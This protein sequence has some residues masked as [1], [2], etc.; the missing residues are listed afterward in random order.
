MAKKIQ[1]DVIANDKASREVKKIGKNTER[2]FKN[3]QSSSAKLGRSMRTSI[4]GAVTS[5]NAGMRTLGSRSNRVFKSMINGAKRYKTSIDNASKSMQNLGRRKGGGLGDA[6]GGGGGFGLASVA[7]IGA[8][9]SLAQSAG[10]ISKGFAEGSKEARTLNTIIRTT[11]GELRTVRETINLNARGL[12]RMTEAGVGGKF[13]S[14][15][16]GKEMK[17]TAAGIQATRQKVNDLNRDFGGLGKTIKQVTGET[18]ALNK[19]FRMTGSVKDNI[20]AVKAAWLK[21]LAVAVAVKV[22][23]DWTKMG[24][25]AMQQQVAFRNMATS[26][27]HDADKILADLK[28]LSGGTVS[29]MV[30]IQKAGTAMMLGIDPSRL[31][32][33]MG[34]ARAT[35]RLTGQEVSEAFGDIAMAVGRQ[36]RMILDNL[37][38]IVNVGE[39]NKRYAKQLKKTVKQLSDYDRK[40]AFLNETIRKGAVLVKQ[41]DVNAKSTSETFQTWGATF[42]N[43]KVTIGKGLVKVFQFIEKMSVVW[44]TVLDQGFMALKFTFAGFG[45][46]L[47]LTFIDAFHEIKTAWAKTVNYIKNKVPDFLKDKLGIDTSKITLPI[48]KM[49]AELRKELTMTREHYEEERER[50]WDVGMGLLD[51]L[52]KAHS[53]GVTK[54]KV[55][56]EAEITSVEIPQEQLDKVKE[57][58]EGFVKDVRTSTPPVEEYEDMEDIMQ[59]IR[60]IQRDIMVENGTWVQQFLYG[61]GL[62]MEKVDSWGETMV[63]IGEQINNVMANN[64]TNAFEDFIDGTKTAKEAF[65][66]Y[67]KNV[68]KWLGQIIVKQLI[69]NGL[70]SLGGMGGGTGWAGI[71][72]SIA[73]TAAKAG[74]GPVSGGKPYL[75]GERGPELFVPSGAGSIKSNQETVEAAPIEVNIANLTDPAMMDAYIASSRGQ[76]AILNVIGQKAGQVRRMVR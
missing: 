33:L 56:V 51:D 38:I 60:A 3:V 10:R 73:S 44:I 19:S 70:K 76:N 18:K 28:R 58:A 36:S 16:F 64:L 7:Q 47:K 15:V 39:A 9:G 41:L 13:Q 21:F 23:V 22:A 31:A 1:I 27:G 43:L 75:V 5:I 45:K 11:S 50:M 48:N 24:A 67:A 69:L 63:Q 2:V 37:G 68:V 14:K 40:Q 55:K 49:G 6:G 25:D 54:Y 32:E 65:A 35:A 29:E 61:V 4:R 17:V 52:S 72:A 42:E 20:V 66:D 8:A 46:S 74:G 53:P 59:R 71:I 34:I 62:S 30:L 26:M 57:F 12:E